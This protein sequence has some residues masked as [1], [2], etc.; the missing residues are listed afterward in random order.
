MEEVLIQCAQ[1]EKDFSADPVHDLR[2]SLRRCRSVADGIRVFDRDSSWKKMRREG[3]QLFSSLGALRDAQVMMEWASKLASEEDSAR[4]NLVQFLARQELASK[5]TARIALQNFDRRQWKSWA[6]KLPARAARISPDARVFA[7]LALERWSEAHALHLRALRNRTHVAFH[8][9]RIGIKRFRYTIENF[10]PR[11]HEHWSKDLKELQDI[12]GEIHD[13][14]VLWE[15]ALKIKAF[16][17]SAER[18]EWRTRLQQMRQERL[19][20]YRAK[21]IGRSSLWLVWRAALPSQDEVR[22]LGFERLRIWASFLD[23][24]VVHTEHVSRLTLEL[25]DGLPLDEIL[26]SSRR[27]AYRWVLRTAAWLHNVGL[28]KTN[29][30]HHKASARLIRK[31]LPPLGWSIGE[32]RMAALVARYHRGALPRETQKRFHTLSPSQQRV[33]QLLGGILRL[34]S[35]CDWQR[36]GKIQRVN[37]EE[38]ASVLTIRAEGYVEATALSEHLAAARHLLELS[39]HRPLLVLPLNE[40]I[41]AQAA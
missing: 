30:G 17:V 18:Q 9:L 33:V 28:S 12:L 38:F 5:K 7:H 20:A 8:D 13:L 19:A 39:Y 29:Q 3:K 1:A 21:M 2:T 37:V 35:A 14:D 32:L 10:L 26:P 24:E 16:S 23:P 31:L 4:R 40:K 27:E 22:A 15:T 36:D 34:A 41:Q 11:L 6:V 25:Y